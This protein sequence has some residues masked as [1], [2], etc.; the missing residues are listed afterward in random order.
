MSAF[1]FKSLLPYT[2]ETVIIQHF[3]DVFSEN[4]REIRDV[5]RSLGGII[6]DKYNANFYDKKSLYVFSDYLSNLQ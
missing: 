1:V 5:A 2:G 6:V 3:K 4:E